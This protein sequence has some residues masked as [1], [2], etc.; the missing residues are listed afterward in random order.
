MVEEAGE[1]LGEVAGEVEVEAGTGTPTSLSLELSP[2]LPVSLAASKQGGTT[3]AVGANL[4][5]RR[6]FLFGL[7]QFGS[8]LLLL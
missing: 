8:V 5:S 7:A 2:L 6:I 4:A 1:D 3:M